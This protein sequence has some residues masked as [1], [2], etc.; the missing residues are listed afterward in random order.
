M[1]GPT[2]PITAK[3]SLSGQD[4]KQGFPR[5]SDNQE[6]ELIKIAA[7]D[8]SIS[9]TYQYKRFKSNDE[10]TILPLK[11]EGND[12]TFRLPALPPAGKVEYSVTLTKGESKVVMTE[13]PVILRYKGP[14]P[15]YILIPHILVLILSIAFAFRAG[16]EALFRR[17]QTYGIAIGTFV[18]LFIGGM[19]L[20]P[21]MQKFA[22]G[23]Y[24]TGWPFGHDLTDNKTAVALI[25]WGIA[26]WKLRKDPAHRTWVFVATIVFL[27][28]FLIPHSVLGSEI[29]YTKK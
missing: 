21:I 4:F 1:T 25:F 2:Y 3:V 12:L 19:I 27:I 10:W 11:R 16:F 13:K 22:F 17:N 18:L 23:A 7:A 29:D 8:T 26:L 15:A 14:V 6:G 20:G 28:V 9:G 5:T 24:W